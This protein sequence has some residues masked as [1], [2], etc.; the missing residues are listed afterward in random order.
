[1]FGGLE[2]KGGGST[3]NTKDETTTNKDDSAV[4]SGSSAFGFLNSISTTTTGTATTSSPSAFS[5][6]YGGVTSTQTTTT[7]VAMSTAPEGVG[8]GF[9]FLNSSS[10][11]NA[12]ME[13]TS[14]A[15]ATEILAAV[16]TSSFSFLNSSMSTET[17]SKD[18]HTTTL[19]AMAEESTHREDATPPTTTSVMSSFSF[20]GGTTKEEVTKP[21]GLSV[22]RET[23][24][25]RSIDALDE[26]ASSNGPVSFVAG[27]GITFGKSGGSIAAVAGAGVKKK[28]TRTAI[29][30]T[31]AQTHHQPSPASQQQASTAA[32]DRPAQASLGI[33]RVTSVGNVSIQ[34]A[35]ADDSIARSI[36]KEDDSLTRQSALEASRRADEFMREKLKEVPNSSSINDNHYDT[37]GATSGS[38]D[39][40]E[41]EED[42]DGI[43]AAARAAAEEAHKLQESKT[44]STT[45]F[46]GL[47][48]SRPSPPTSRH[49]SATESPNPSSSGLRKSHHKSSNN[50]TEQTTSS[51]PPAPLPPSQQQS[52]QYHSPNN[53]SGGNDSETSLADILRQQQEEILQRSARSHKTTIAGVPD[54]Y[55]HTSTPIAVI[56]VPLPPSHNQSR[57]QNVKV[58]TTSAGNIPDILSIQS[59][60][61]PKQMY[62]SM[63]RRFREKVLRATNEVTKLRQHRTGLLEERHVTAAKER[64]AGQQKA[65]AE[66]QQM[67]AAEA[68]EFELADEM[69]M[70]IDKY[71][72]EK[73]EYRAIL[74]NIQRALV[75]L[76]STKKA[77]VEQ[78]VNCFR[79]IQDEMQS[80]HKQTDAEDTKDAM[81]KMQQFSNVSKVL[82]A[83]NER[84]Q[85]DWKHLQRDIELAA[86][87]RKEVESAISMQA[88][89][90]EKERDTAKG[91]LT[92]VESEIEEL[93]KQLAAKQTI[94]A[95]LR[96]EIAGYEESVLKVR[97]KF[98]RQLNRVQ[99][100]EMEI[101]DTQYEWDAEKANFELQREAHE[102]QMSAHSERLLQR[103]QL[104]EKLSKEI[105]IAC[106]FE[107]IIVSEDINFFDGYQQTVPSDETNESN[108]GSHSSDSLAQL[109][110]DVVKAEAAKNDANLVMKAAR[111]AL[112]SLEEEMKRLDIVIP[113]YEEMKKA[114]ASRRDFKTA[115]NA[116]KEIKEASARLK[117]IQDE[118]L[119]EAKQKLDSAESELGVKE[120]ELQKAID[121]A[122][123]QEKHSGLEAM[124]GIAEGIRKLVTIKETICGSV[125]AGQDESGDDDPY[126]IQS[127]GAL[128]LKAQ[129]DSLT[130]EGQAYGHKFGKWDELIQ[131]VLGEQNGSISEQVEK[132]MEESNNDSNDDFENVVAEE[133]AANVECSVE[134]TTTE[135]DSH[136]DTLSQEE[137]LVKFRDLTNRLKEVEDSLEDAVSVEDFEKADSLQETLEQL[138]NDLN[139]LNMTDDEVERA[140]Q[141]SSVPDSATCDNDAAPST[142][143]VD[144]PEKDSD[145][146]N[147]VVLDVASST[148][149]KIDPG[150]EVHDDVLPLS[151]EV[152]PNVA[153]QSNNDTCTPN[154]EDE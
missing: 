50:E 42:A 127:V 105:A 109:Q 128:I 82:S 14:S 26:L 97:V 23:S 64:L 7:D 138:V 129:I 24:T 103:D 57:Q 65:A 43:I 39:D 99:K 74:E 142:T 37:R 146:N 135:N 143:E 12:E 5:F 83:E 56:P 119:D 78:I 35:A 144:D 106:K 121:I 60:P 28:R 61:T 132:K 63:L 137:K 55:E 81:Q 118:L 131:G 38:T 85:Q 1:M 140:L 13:D 15:T 54:A 75:Q 96:T 36:S 2:L 76:E 84:L 20:L 73:V 40:S 30:G 48:R 49:N 47:F 53:I 139:N 115:G 117:Q 87:E 8:S 21:S 130:F 100:K 112:I 19:P 120:I 88:G 32:I 71:E 147:E 150:I 70:V 67:A 151:K 27:S 41:E 18:S 111:K 124:E 134:N 108:G 44:K 116:S 125:E 101:Q 6:L 72:R 69:S 95:Q 17:T 91:K 11:Q 77:C 133:S 98:S 153:L 58:S 51:R 86:E 10:V 145:K 52:R 152:L 66:A 90:F 110:A 45:V 107:S 149:D 102:M 141:S 34:S 154:V 89:E 46:G 114:A 29:V 9:S 33:N 31:Q 4:D 3:I 136:V 94:A 59:P 126:S 22:S 123:E 93:R 148:D 25:G 104:L 16:S 122:T 113:E 80:F 62:N 68:E 79:D 92:T